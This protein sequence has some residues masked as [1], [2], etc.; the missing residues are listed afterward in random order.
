MLRVERLKVTEL[1]LHG[2]LDK[3]AGRDRAILYASGILQTQSYM[4]INCW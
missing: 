3:L 2:L 1:S 4:M